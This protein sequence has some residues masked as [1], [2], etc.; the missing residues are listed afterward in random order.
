[1][2]AKWICCFSTGRC[3]YTQG[4]NS[5]ILA[6]QIVHW[7]LSHF[8]LAYV[9]N[10]NIGTQFSN[11]FI[12]VRRHIAYTDGHL[13]ALCLLSPNPVILQNILFFPYDRTSSDF[14]TRVRT[15]HGVR[16]RDR[17]Q[18]WVANK[19]SIIS[20]LLHHLRHYRLFHT[21]TA[22]PF[23]SICR[24]KRY[25]NSREDD[26]DSRRLCRGKCPDLCPAVSKWL[27]TM[28]ARSGSMFH[29]QVSSNEVKHCDRRSRPV[30]MLLVIDMHS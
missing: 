20:V 4:G 25:T 3:E 6:L 26:D 18:Q 30:Q 17:L 1:M 9:Y 10:F 19:L 28:Q 7:Y 8:V 16:N 5:E 15:E 11:R 13:V 21:N 23:S 14:C 24:Y 2:V 29:G 12:D 22:C 27:L